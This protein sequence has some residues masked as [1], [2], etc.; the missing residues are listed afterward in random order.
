MD[1]RVVGVYRA[2][3]AALVAKVAPMHPKDERADRAAG[4]WET[5]DEEMGRSELAELGL[6]AVENQHA[7]C[8]VAKAFAQRDQARSS[9]HVEFIPR[10]AVS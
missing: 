6:K 2:R 1:Q 4:Q 8:Y 5:G 7:T 10:P 9:H 3:T